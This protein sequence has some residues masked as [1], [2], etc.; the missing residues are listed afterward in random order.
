MVKRL[1]G[2][3]RTH[4]FRLRREYLTQG[5]P[6]FRDKCKGKPKELLTKK[7]RD[8][9]IETVKTKAPKDL[10]TYYENYDHWT[11]SVLGHWIEEKYEVKYKSKTSLYLVFRKAV[12]TYHK[13][14]RVYDK[15]DEV[16]VEKWK[17]STKPKLRKYWKEK[18][19]VILCADEMILIPFL[20]NNFPKKRV[21]ARESATAA[22]P[23]RYAK[24]FGQAIQESFK[25]WIAT[26]PK[27][28]TREDGRE[29][30]C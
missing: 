18:D 27:T 21:I 30:V 7:Q 20:E 14:G 6:A 11:T 28:E 24:R 15:H 13:P 22:R 23:H 19:T 25:D 2:F 3:E 8:E 16:E 4:A 29:R 26:F 9:I 10:G 17:R 1:T 5:L 12:F